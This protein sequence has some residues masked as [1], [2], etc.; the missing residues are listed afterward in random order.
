MLNFQTQNPNLGKSWRALQRKVLVYFTA[1]WYT[2]WPFGIFDG[3]L[4]HFSR[5]GMLQQEK[6]GKPAVV[7]HPF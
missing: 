7:T 1:I 3:H 5:F 6:S 2:S 4:V